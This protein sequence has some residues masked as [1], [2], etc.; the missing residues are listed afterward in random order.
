MHPPV[1]HRNHYQARDPGYGNTGTGSNLEIALNRMRLRHVQTP[2]WYF[3][4]SAITMT[5]WRR[6][7]TIDG[8]GV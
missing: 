6:G 4:G 8:G 7:V 3:M 1:L 5:T 2:C